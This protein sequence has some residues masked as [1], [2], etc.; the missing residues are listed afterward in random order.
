MEQKRTSER[1]RHCGHSRAA[2]AGRHGQGC[3]PHLESGKHNKQGDRRDNII[4]CMISITSYQSLMDLSLYVTPTL[5][6]FDVASTV[7]CPRHRHD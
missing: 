3:G 4:L 7:G 5:Y 1:A 6:G 2:T